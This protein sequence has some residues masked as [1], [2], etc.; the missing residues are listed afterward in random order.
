M[1]WLIAVS[2]A[3]HER[4]SGDYRAVHAPPRSV[5]AV[6]SVVADRPSAVERV[7]VWQM[8][9]QSEVGKT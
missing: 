5:L 4:E 3:F 1:F 6:I 9:C 8:A 7:G 2:F